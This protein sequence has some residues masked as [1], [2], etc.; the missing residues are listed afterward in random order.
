VRSRRPPTAGAVTQPAD[1]RGPKTGFAAPVAPAPAWRAYA[2]CVH[3]PGTAGEAGEA[4][5][6]AGGT[7]PAAGTGTEGARLRVTRSLSIPLAE[8]SWRATTPGGPGGQHANRTSSRVE[9][10][11]DVARSAALGPRQRAR[12]LERLGPV[13]RATAADDR[14]QARNRQVALERLA[15]RLAGALRVEPPRRPT[16]PTRGSKERRLEGKRRR[17]E[18]KRGRRPA[19]DGT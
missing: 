14:S 11:F 10:R 7:G 12:I 19:A 4:G 3:E 16:A 9:V 5:E 13:V 2:R 17:A 6:T 1:G 8:I 18:V 15:V